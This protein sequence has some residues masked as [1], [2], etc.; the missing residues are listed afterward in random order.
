M[1]S[2]GGEFYCADSS[3]RSGQGNAVAVEGDGIKEYVIAA[4]LVV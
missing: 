4:L 2:Y 3:K 1:W